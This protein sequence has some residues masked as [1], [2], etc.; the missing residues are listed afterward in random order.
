MKWIRE[1]ERGA[2]VGENGYL[3]QTNKQTPRKDQ[4]KEKTKE[5]NKEIK[6]KSRD[7][8]SGQVQ[9]EYQNDLF[10]EVGT[11][12]RPGH[13]YLKQLIKQLNCQF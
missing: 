2:G 12:T 4:T 3:R 1:R 9:G 13:G 6:V 10:I 5:C 8:G 11:F 7:R